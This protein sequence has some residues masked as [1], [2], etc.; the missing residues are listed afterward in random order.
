M[1]VV[2]F[3]RPKLKDTYTILFDD[4]SYNLYNKYKWRLIAC[5]KKM[6][7]AR[8]SGKKTVLFHREL[9]GLDEFSDRVVDHMDSNTLNNQ[10]DNLRIC[11]IS[12]NNRNKVNTKPTKGYYLNSNGKWQVQ[13]RL[14]GKNVCLG[15]FSTE[16]QAANVY[17]Q[18]CTE[19]GLL[20]ADGDRHKSMMQNRIN[21]LKKDLHNVQAS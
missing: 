5:N 13:M 2:E 10:V 21:S 20:L 3:T 18:K 15:C 17:K 1:I 8:H 11:S 19:L 9:L 7:L 12:E 16:E 6:Y 4:V 14:D